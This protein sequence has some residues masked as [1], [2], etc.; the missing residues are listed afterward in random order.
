MTIGGYPEIGVAEAR[1]RHAEYRAMIERGADPA[2][3]KQAEKRVRQARLSE[4]DAKDKF[5]T[6]SQTWLAEKMAT[7]SP[8]YRKQ[9]QSFLER[10]VWP[11]IGERRFGEVKPM[12]ILRIIESLRSSPVTAERMRVTIQ[13]IFDYAIQKLIVVVNPALP[14]RGVIERPPVEHHRHLNE[15]ELGRFWRSLAMQR[16]HFTTLAAAKL[17]VY[18]MCRKSEVLRAKWEEFDLDAAVWDIPAVRMKSRLPHRVFL[19][20]QAVELMRLVHA[21]SGRQE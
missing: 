7:K 6:F 14:L 13:R 15:R 16:A 20:N 12:D 17:L 10:F 2:Q 21:F 8:T 3:H 9:S 19:S 4:S 5:Q 11:E 18:S 1:E